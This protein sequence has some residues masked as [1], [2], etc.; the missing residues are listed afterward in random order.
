MLARQQQHVALRRQAHN[1]CHFVR[2][3]PRACN[4]RFFTLALHVAHGDQAQHE[5]IFKRPQLL[6]TQRLQRGAVGGGDSVGELR[7]NGVRWSNEQPGA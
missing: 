5:G 7:R 2:L 1:T 4:A 3:A 6:V